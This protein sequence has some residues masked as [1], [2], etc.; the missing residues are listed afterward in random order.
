MAKLQIHPP[1]ER[2]VAS[3]ISAAFSAPP[4]LQ[5][6]GGS[7]A[8]RSR[9]EAI[10][11]DIVRLAEHAAYCCTGRPDLFLPAEARLESVRHSLGFAFLLRA[12]RIYGSLTG[13]GG[14]GSRSPIDSAPR[15]RRDILSPLVNQQDRVDL[16]PQISTPLAPGDSEEA[17]LSSS[18]SPSPLLSLLLDQLADRMRPWFQ[19]HTDQDVGRL[20]GL[21]MAAATL[22]KVLHPKLNDALVP[23]PPISAEAVALLL[24]QVTFPIGLLMLP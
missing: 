3:L 12:I 17:L 7:T 6:P 22:A 9:P 13:T 18:A 5:G 1:A 19:P 2:T 20:K 8:P 10:H 15:D 14:G 11:A 24:G 23:L 16:S 4:L 21:G